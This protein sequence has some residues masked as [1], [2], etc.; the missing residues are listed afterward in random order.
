M[1]LQNDMTII[2]SSK[3]VLVPMTTMNNVGFPRRL[4]TLFVNPLDGNTYTECEMRLQAC[5][6]T[7]ELI[8]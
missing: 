2:A 7:K 3:L 8:A 6:N 4:M 5:K 1:T